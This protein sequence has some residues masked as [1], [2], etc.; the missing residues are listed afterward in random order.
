MTFVRACVA[1]AILGYGTF[2]IILILMKEYYHVES[3]FVD[4]ISGW[5][6]FGS[7]VAWFVVMMAFWIL[8]KKR[9]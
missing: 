3:A 9:Q 1:V 4:K 6:C 5:I 8:P 7:G 2:L